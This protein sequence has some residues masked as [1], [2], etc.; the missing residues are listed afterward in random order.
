LRI[1]AS[2]NRRNGGTTTNSG[3]KAVPAPLLKS[4][5]PP[6]VPADSADFQSEFKNRCKNRTAVTW[7]TCFSRQNP[8]P[9]VGGYHSW[10]HPDPIP[11]V[12]EYSFHYR[13]N[14]RY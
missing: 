5:Y 11:L 14:R 9:Y 10:T 4:T 1:I 6:Q 3:D 13:E 12:F 2:R 8:P 7:L